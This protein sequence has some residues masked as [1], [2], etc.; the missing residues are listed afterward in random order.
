MGIF[1]GEAMNTVLKRV[2]TQFDLTKITLNNLSQYDITPTAKLVLLYLTDCYNPKHADVFPKQKTIALKLGVSERSV[3]RAIQE[4][5]KAGLILIECKNTNRYI[6]MPNMT[7]QLSQRVNTKG[8][9]HTPKN[10]PEKM[11]EGM[12]KNVTLQ[13]DKLS[14]PCIITKKKEQI[15][16]KEVFIKT[17][18]NVYSEEGTILRDYAI[19]HGARN[20]NAYIN[21]LKSTG[22]AAK[23]IKEYKQKQKIVRN[24][25]AMLLD[26]QKQIQIYQEYAQEAVEPETSIAWQELGKKLG[27]KK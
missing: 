25:M 22:S 18:G 23:I 17:G 15:N 24:A 3:I 12:C 8:V 1:G 10:Y 2:E 11:T 20:I 4:L 7:T 27:I 5:V 19:K 6:L 26:T 16:N 14:S 13:T 21:T 9:N